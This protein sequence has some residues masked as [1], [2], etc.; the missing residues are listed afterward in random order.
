[1]SNA[2]KSAAMVREAFSKK[3]A[4]RRNME[5]AMAEF[6]A[7]TSRGR[8]NVTDQMI[9]NASQAQVDAVRDY[10]NATSRLE[11]VK[12]AAKNMKGGKRRTHRKRT[13]RKRKH[14]RRH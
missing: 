9:R 11:Q 12:R 5:A 6:T 10:E 7:V 8:T 14:T 3:L 1:M 13:H 4:A 2:N